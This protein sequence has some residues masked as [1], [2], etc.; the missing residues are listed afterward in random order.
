MGP[1]A[2]RDFPG[3]RAH[4]SIIRV[5]GKRQE[6]TDRVRWWVATIRPPTTVLFR[7]ARISLPVAL[8][9]LTTPLLSTNLTLHA[10]QFLY[11]FLIRNY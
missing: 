6:H 8:Y 10:D 11:E 9:P 1:G 4:L 5:Y 3:R 7:V 2:L